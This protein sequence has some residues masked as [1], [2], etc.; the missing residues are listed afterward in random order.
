ML[1]SSFHGFLRLGSGISPRI[2]FKEVQKV[3]PHM[4]T[5]R[6]GKPGDDIFC[7]PMM[8]EHMNDAV[9]RAARKNTAD[10]IRILKVSCAH[11]APLALGESFVLRGKANSVS[12]D[13]AEFHVLCSTVDEKKV[14]GDATIT[15]K[16]FH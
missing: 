1:S 9:L 10:E 4:T 5:N 14:L 8:I 6:T 12:G 15:I 2:Q 11:K 16:V 7:T 3:L 13:T